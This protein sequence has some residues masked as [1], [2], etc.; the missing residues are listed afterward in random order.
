MPQSGKEKPPAQAEGL[1]S[2]QRSGHE[3]GGYSHSIIYGMH[4]QLTDNNFPQPDFHRTVLYTVTG[5]QYHENAMS[6]DQR[7]VLFFTDSSGFGGP[8]S[9]LCQLSVSLERFAE[10]VGKQNSG[11]GG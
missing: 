8:V 4:N 3:A 6:P 5:N 11:V 1:Y 9:V 7:I 10:H 2:L